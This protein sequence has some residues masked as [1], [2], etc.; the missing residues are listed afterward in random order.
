MQGTLLNKH[1]T[2]CLHTVNWFPVLTFNMNNS[3]Y[4]VFLSNTGPV[5]WNCR[6]HNCI[7]AEEQDSPNEC[8]GNDTK[9]PDSESPVM[10]ELWRIWN[11]SSL[12]SLLGPLWPRMV[13]PDMFLFIGQIGLN[14]VFMLNWI[15]WNRIVF[16]FNCVYF[17]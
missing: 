6:I 13:A 5:G 11:T 17:C 9:Q 2:M 8:P 7:S 10:L 4:Q 3:I 12:P 15:V 16:T 14:C 1:M